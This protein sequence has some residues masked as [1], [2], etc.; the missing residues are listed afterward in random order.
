[1]SCDNNDQLVMVFEDYDE[2]KSGMSQYVYI[3]DQML[4]KTLVYK[5]NC[6]RAE[7]TNLVDFVA[8]DNN[9]YIFCI[10]YIIQKNSTNMVIYT[11]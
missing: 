4:N 5:T 10:I 7:N 11:K 8:V 3:V 2:E 6:Y 1:M 9:D